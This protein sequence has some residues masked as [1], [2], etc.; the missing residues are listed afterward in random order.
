MKGPPTVTID[1]RR[2][3]T[4]WVQTLLDVPTISVLFQSEFPFDILQSGGLSKSETL[5]VDKGI[6]NGI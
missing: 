1:I 3:R 6:L 5:I 4:I 2:L